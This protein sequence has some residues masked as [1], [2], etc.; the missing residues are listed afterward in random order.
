VDATRALRVG[1][2]M[3]AATQ[4]GPLANPR[5][6]AKM[7]SLV[8]DA[9]AQGA[10]LLLGGKRIAGPGY[11]FEPTILADVPMNAR[12]MHEEPFGPIAVLRPFDGLDDALA[13][14]NRLPYGLSAYAFTR[15]ARTVL[16]VSDG[17]E[18]GMIGIN[19]YRIVATEL[20]FGGIKESGIGSEGGIEG[21]QPYLVNKFISQI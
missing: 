14:A 16:D 5:Q 3:D 11:F 19:Q 2:G 15:D 20:P 17:L 4:V 10:R 18:A 6:L 12:V 1:D 21:I 7:A 9:V 8:E 13:E